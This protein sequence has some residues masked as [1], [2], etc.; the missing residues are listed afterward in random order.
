MKYSPLIIEVDCINLLKEIDAGFDK[1][2]GN[3]FG[4][5]SNHLRIFNPPA[6]LGLWIEIVVAC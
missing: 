5:P 1:L 4:D 6:Q 2:V 3:Y